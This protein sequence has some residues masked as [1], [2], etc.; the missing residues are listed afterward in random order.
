MT[1]CTIFNFF[2]PFRPLV[3]LSDY[4][5]RKI[6]YPFPLKAVTLFM[7]D[8]QIKVSQLQLDFWL[9]VLFV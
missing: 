2:R 9:L 3:T 6:R 4:Y 8:P 7:N 5:R 1:S